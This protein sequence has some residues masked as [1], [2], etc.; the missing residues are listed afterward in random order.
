MF[1]RKQGD[2]TPLWTIVIFESDKS[3]E[4]KPFKGDFDQA[5]V[6]AKELLAFYKSM[7]DVFKV[8]HYTIE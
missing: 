8:T 4:R 2:T 7:P 5:T 3:L 6:K 1:N